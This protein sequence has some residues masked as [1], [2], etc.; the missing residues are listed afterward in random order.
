MSAVDYKNQRCATCLF[1]ERQGAQIAQAIRDPSIEPD[2]GVCR[3]NPP[4]FAKQASWPVGMFPRVHEARWCGQWGPVE[5]GGD[6]G[7]GE[8]VVPFA[9]PREVT[10]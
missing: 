9:R 8:T 2:A 6:D 4:V 10:V 1:F 7:G 5:G 3:F